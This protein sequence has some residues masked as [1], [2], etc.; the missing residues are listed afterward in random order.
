MEVAWNVA[1]QILATGIL[2]VFVALS[3]LALIMWGFGIIHSWRQRSGE[4]AASRETEPTI[5]TPSDAHTAA[6]AEDRASV[7]LSISE[8]VG[9]GAGI[10]SDF[11]NFKVTVDGETY[12]VSVEPEGSPIPGV[13]PRRQRIP[14]ATSPETTPRKK[15]E[16]SPDAKDGV[17]SPMQGKII[18]IMVK[19]GDKVEKGDVLAILEAMK[20]ENEVIAPKSGIIT[21]IHVA[22]GV[23]VDANT[24]LFTIE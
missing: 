21:K 22:E 11:G 2:M 17:L 16:L 18:Q 6:V 9:G 14:V 8:P 20:M 23:A 19:K 13:K 12:D 5:P 15:E 3:L 4:S 24:P 10:T 7:R 1:T